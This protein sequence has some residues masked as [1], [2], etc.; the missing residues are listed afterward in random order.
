[1]IT[2]VRT[3]WL[4]LLL[5][6]G[7]LRIQPQTEQPQSTRALP[8]NRF[9][10]SRHAGTDA[11]GFYYMPTAIG[12]DYFDGTSPIERVR[13]HFAAAK[14]AG[15]KY[16][17]CAF[18]WD[19]IEK[20]HGKYDWQF[21]DNLMAIAE[22]NKIQVIPY[23]AYTPEWAARDKKDFWKQPPRDPQ[24]YADFMFAAAKR[25]RGRIHSWEIWN[26]PD[27]KDY[28]LGSADE[29]ATLVM[30]A[31][32]RIREA[33]PAAV[34][35][36]GGMA[37]GPSDFFRALSRQHHVD[38]Y[39]D[40]IAMHAYPEGWLNG[41]AELIFQ[42]WVPQ[43]QKIIAE[44]GSGD[45]LWLNEM[46]Y[47]DYRFRANQ[48]SIYGTHVFY[49]YEH[50]R[51][52]QAVMLFKMEVLALAT[53][54]ISLAGWYRIDDFPRSEKRLGPDLVNYHLGVVD[55][56]G[57]AKPALFALRFFNRI[58]NQPS[59]LLQ[60]QIARREKS[61]AVVDVFQRKDK[62]VIV[63]GWLRS[64][65]RDEVAD[66]SG[67]A[68]DRRAEVVSAEL[69]CAGA[70][71]SGFYDAEG[72]KVTRSARVGRGMLKDIHLSGSKVFVAELSCK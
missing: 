23:V 52:Y 32:R 9:A 70:R 3:A 24:L 59:R 58:F 51:R 37:N 65:T 11:S 5:V 25:H 62:H 72:A 30:Q 42:Q 47:A 20:E 54:Q 63:V 55:V 27:N 57:Q 19:A 38:R 67:M 17:R 12:D 45:D 1:M 39:V 66:R 43:M 18:S 46:G 26:E 35:V 4:L 34:L 21:W 56:R 41:P 13:R 69:P 48:A 16:L 7:S 8:L 22:Q 31:A 10:A 53:Q 2:S 36:L 15:A 29:F 68:V 71:V 64:S 60:V 40:V 44:A 28:W 14:R 61:Q 50:S 49:N 6:A 33:D